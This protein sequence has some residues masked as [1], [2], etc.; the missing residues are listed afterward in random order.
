[1]AVHERRMA[2]YYA[3]MFG[4]IGFT[5]PF[6]APWLAELGVDARLTGVIVALPSIAMVVTT[7]YLG[8]LADRLNDWRTAI[9]AS[10]WA[11]F[12]LLSWLLIRHDV[13]DII[14]VWT[15]TGLLIAARIPIVDSATLSLLRRKGGHYGP[16]RAIGSVGFVGA[17]LVAGPLFD[18]VGFDLYVPLLVLGAGLRAI[19]ST[20]LPALRAPSKV[21]LE[22]V[23]FSEHRV[24]EPVPVDNLTAPAGNL[25]SAP[26]SFTSPS[27]GGGLHHPGFLLVLVGAALINASHAFFVWFG[28]LH[29]TVHVTPLDA[30]ESARVTPSWTTQRSLVEP[31]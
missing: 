28:M 10:D 30:R 20:R 7:L 27:L 2:I 22:P 14:V 18:V 12:V 21:D 19:A 23:M 9:V 29:A 15:L 25:V 13:A 24:E 3:I 16:I 5:G 1:M 11:V 31:C 8:S 4:A 6:F 17:L 26:A